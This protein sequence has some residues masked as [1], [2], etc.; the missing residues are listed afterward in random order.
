MKTR[1]PPRLRPPFLPF[2]EAS[3]LPIPE[4]LAG[5]DHLLA[6]GGEDLLEKDTQLAAAAYETAPSVLHERL[7]SLRRRRNPR[8]CEQ[9]DAS[10][11]QVRYQLRA[12]RKLFV[13]RGENP[14]GGLGAA[15]R[16]RRGDGVAHATRLLFRR[17][18]VGAGPHPILLR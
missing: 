1:A 11:D 8:S 10:S 6:Y 13:Q 17:D 7:Y 12:E 14:D 16:D 18:P 15:I 9:R 4:K 5:A 3:R 2:S